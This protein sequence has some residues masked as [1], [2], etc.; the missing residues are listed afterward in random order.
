MDVCEQ[1]KL[2]RC[3]PIIKCVTH[4]G[5]CF[6]CQ[7]LFWVMCHRMRKVIKQILCIINFVNEPKITNRSLTFFFSTAYH[8]YTFAFNLY[9]PNICEMRCWFFWEF[10]Y[11][12]KLINFHF[13][14]ITYHFFNTSIYNKSNRVASVT[15]S[16]KQRT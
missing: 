7:V 13:Y 15:A 4:T 11:N 2:K 14:Y 3:L 9:V 1:K 16:K 8:L 5:L 10:F 12:I 6:A